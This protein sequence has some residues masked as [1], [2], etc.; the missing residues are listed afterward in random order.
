[1]TPWIRICPGKHEGYEQSYLQT[2][3]LSEAMGWRTSVNSWCDNDCYTDP[4]TQR[5]QA[6]ISALTGIPP[7]HAEYLQML[8]Y[9]VPQYYKVRGRGW[10]APTNHCTKRHTPVIEIS[11]CALIVI[12]LINVPWR[13]QRCLLGMPATV[14]RLRYARAL[15]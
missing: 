8:K 4:I 15:C 10:T 13:S 12:D 14:V 9:V 1:M 3:N 7:S 5:V 2:E 11:L 6:R